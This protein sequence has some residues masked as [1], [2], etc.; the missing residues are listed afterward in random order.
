MMHQ[1]AY[2]ELLSLR[3]KNKNISEE[4]QE[5]EKAYNFS[6]YRF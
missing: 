4:V 5:E 6:G 3:Y 2:A 1:W